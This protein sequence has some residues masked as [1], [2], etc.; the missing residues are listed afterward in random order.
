MPRFMATKIRTVTKLTSLIEQIDKQYETLSDIQADGD[1]SGFTSEC[2]G[3]YHI[4]SN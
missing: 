4:E 3:L 1:T 2:L